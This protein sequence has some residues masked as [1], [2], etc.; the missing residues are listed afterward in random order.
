[1]TKSVF[2]AF[3][4]L[5]LSP[6]ARA[7][8]CVVLRPGDVDVVLPTKPLPIE[9]FAADELTNFLSRVLGAPVPVVGKA[10][11]RRTAILLGRATGFDV[12]A[13]ERDAFRT[14]VEIA[15]NGL[16]VVRIAGRDGK[17]DIFRSVWKYG[18]STYYERA[19]LFGVYAFL[20]DFA[21]V[22]FYFPGELGTVANRKAAVRVPVQ[23]KVTAP[24]FP[25]RS[26]YSWRDGEWYEP[27]PDGWHKDSGKALNCLRMRFETMKIP[28]CHG[29]NKF[30]IVERF[31]A[32]HPEYCQLRK[33][34]TRCTSLERERIGYHQKQLCQSSKVWD[35]FHD[36]I[37]AD[38]RTGY[39]DVMPQDGYVPC[40]CQECQAAYRRNPDGT[41]PDSYAS[42]L[43]W[44]QT[45]KLARRFIAEGRNDLTFTQMSYGAYKEVPNL[46]LP[47]NI[48]VMVAVSGPWYH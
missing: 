33:D 21:G 19:T 3:V 24:W 48:L 38:G 35:V 39:V 32:T 43:V 36:D 37:V 7:E 10:E 6:L 17:G 15:S 42:E 30:K 18:Q 22:R 9:R 34:G 14:K 45:A 4:V 26:V 1:M 44:G 12:S 41:L 28:C 31:A 13:F 27:L 25:V 11:G 47:T 29:Q 16:S 8:E 46:D 2:L 5:A 23:D 40:E 20:E